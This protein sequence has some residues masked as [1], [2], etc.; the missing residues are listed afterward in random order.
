LQQTIAGILNATLPQM[1]SSLFT[2]AMGQAKEKP[3]PQAPMMASQPEVAKP[4]PEIPLDRLEHATQEVG[5]QGID[6]EMVDKS[7]HVEASTVGVD[8]A[9]LAVEASTPPEDPPTT[10]D[11]KVSTHSECLTSSLETMQVTE[12]PPGCLIQVGDGAPV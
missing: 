9:T 10:A 5:V 2:E 11:A 4:A 6:T 8:K 12:S 1:L 3:T 7:T